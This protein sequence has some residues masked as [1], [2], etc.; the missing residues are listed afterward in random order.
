MTILY[1]RRRCKENETTT[2]RVNHHGPRGRN[3]VPVRRPGR[4]DRVGGQRLVL[5]VDA[6]LHETRPRQELLLVERLDVL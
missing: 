1:L 6:D 3:M 5:A 4:R 2:L